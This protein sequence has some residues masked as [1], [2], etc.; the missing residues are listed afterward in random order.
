MKRL[1]LSLALAISAL[2]LITPVSFA[3]D[4]IYISIKKECINAA[5]KDSA[6]IAEVGIAKIDSLS[7]LLEK[8]DFSVVNKIISRECA[9]PESSL[10]KHPYR[11]KFTLNGCRG[12]LVSWFKDTILLNPNAFSKSF[13]FEGT[14]IHEYIHSV[15]LI[16][17]INRGYRSFKWADTITREEW[18]EK[19]WSYSLPGIPHL[20][21]EG[22]T[23]WLTMRVYWKLYHK[24]L[25][26]NWLYKK[27]VAA[28]QKIAKIIGPEV[29]MYA[30]LNGDAEC[31]QRSFDSRLGKNAWQEYLKR[32]SVCGE[33][34]TEK[35]AQKIL[36]ITK[37]FIASRLSKIKK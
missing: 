34:N 10:T 3:E 18:V 23:E 25:A 9:I 5:K 36:S 27:P 15:T 17:S 32:L 30:Y 22:V 4:S 6:L 19:G 11:I 20:L 12:G 13:P 2:S 37:S 33:R 8:F 16:D 24:K 35:D 31:M 14:L 7:S 1:I 21:N 29:L 28:V 26:P